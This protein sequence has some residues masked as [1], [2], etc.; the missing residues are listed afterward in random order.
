MQSLCLWKFASKSR[1]SVSSFI[2]MDIIGINGDHLNWMSE[3]AKRL[4]INKKGRC[5]G[6]VLDEVT[7][8][9]RLLMKPRI[10][11]L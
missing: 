2:Y 6:L 9:V 10:L 3:E 11:L 5:G 1:S 8:Q 7:I 4:K